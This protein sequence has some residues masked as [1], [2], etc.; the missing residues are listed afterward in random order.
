MAETNDEIITQIVARH[1]K[2]LETKLLELKLPQL[3]YI[4]V[5]K[6]FRWL[7]TDLKKAIAAGTSDLKN[8]K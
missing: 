5:S 3:V 7:E 2:K 8:L 1:F 6:E 4:A